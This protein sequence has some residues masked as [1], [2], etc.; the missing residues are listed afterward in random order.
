MNY[1]KTK[2]DGYK[3]NNCG[4][5][6]TNKTLAEICCKLYKCDICNIELP[7][8]RTKCDKCKYEEYFKNSRKYTVVEYEKEFPNHMVWYNYEYYSSVQDFKDTYLEYHSEL[9][10][11]IFGTEKYR[12]EVDIES[13]LNSA[14]ENSCLEDFCF[15]NKKELIEF[16][17]KWNK[18]NGA[19]AYM[20]D[21]AVCIIIEV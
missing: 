17:N 12:I 11:Y 2:I 15:E 3:C 5:E 4:S 6:T 21:K 14:E 7:R 19:W 13:E 16:V 18:K 20:L 1:K 9:P 10:K 8:F